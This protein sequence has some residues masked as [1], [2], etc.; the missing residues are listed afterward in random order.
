MKQT[1]YSRLGFLAMLAVYAMALL[2]AHAQERFPSKPVRLIVPYTAG[3]PGD[4]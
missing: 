4:R 2:M 3:G 1:R